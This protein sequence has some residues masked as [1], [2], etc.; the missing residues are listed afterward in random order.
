MH[1]AFAIEFVIPRVAVKDLKRA[2]YYQFLGLC[3][4]SVNILVVYHFSFRSF[5]I[6]VLKKKREIIVTFMNLL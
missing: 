5:D 1:Q 2:K 3:L 4:Q 6:N